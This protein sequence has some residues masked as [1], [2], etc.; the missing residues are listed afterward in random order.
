M[1]KIR[2]IYFQ[3]YF[4]YMIAL[5]ILILGI[6][7]YPTFNSI[8][9][10]H[11]QRN[12]YHSEEFIQDFE[13]N[14]EWFS[15]SYFVNSDGEDEVILYDSIE[16]YRSDTLRIFYKSNNKYL[17]TFRETINDNSTYYSR[18]NEIEEV[19]PQEYELGATYYQNFH[20]DG[21]FIPILMVALGF[22][23]FFVDQKTNFNRLLFSL[24]EKRRKLFLGKLLYVALPIIGVTVIGI[25]SS[26]LIQYM[27]I[28]APYLNASLL[29]MVYSG[30]SQL[31]FSIF[32]LT[33]GIFFGTLLNNLVLAPLALITGGYFILY[34]GYSFYYG[35][36]NILTYFFPNIRMLTPT[37]LTRFDLGKT[38]TP[39]S[40]ILF[41]VVF[42]LLL[43]FLA[44]KIFNKIALE[45]EGDFVT[46][47]NL[48][49]PTFL[50]LFIGSTIYFG[51][52]LF[53]LYSVLNMIQF[54]HL[55]LV[56]I[57]RNFLIV[58][59]L[60]FT[61]SFSL[62]YHRS[63]IKWFQERRDSHLRQQMNR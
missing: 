33:I 3:R 25:L 38:G 56:D 34:T 2:T 32:S 26:I 7:I 23:L 60:V 6:Y 48:R 24:S 18:Y 61:V 52:A 27:G 55:G 1:E 59:A 57:L 9:A 31:I 15:K 37:S 39:L 43:L 53:D 16:D 21:S 5:S 40:G 62:V 4:G 11:E 58:T 22:L 36:N 30:F 14:P 47:T 20:N 19:E 63:I 46:N 29:Q 12:Y 44:E 8:N 54:N 49:R 50:S 35:I 17:E 45:N 41:W 42:S 10:W 28:P 51:I 13:Q